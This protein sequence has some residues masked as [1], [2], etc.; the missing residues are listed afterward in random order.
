VLLTAGLALAVLFAGV[1]VIAEYDHTHIDAAGDRVP[2]GEDCRIC[3]EI[4]IALRLIE[5]FARLGASFFFA[6]C[7]LAVMPLIKPQTF[8]CAINPF[9]LKVK[10][11]C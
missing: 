2:A 8:L 7:V 9:V 5:A 6:G 10:L 11:N 3:L 1:F 4:Q